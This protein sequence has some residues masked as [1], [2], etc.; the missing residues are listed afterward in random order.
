MEAG[1]GN[2]ASGQSCRTNRPHPPKRVASRKLLPTESCPHLAQRGPRSVNQSATASTRSTVIFEL[3]NWKN[4][5]LRRPRGT[6]RPGKDPDPLPI[7]TM[8]FAEFG[9]KRR[10]RRSDAR[11]ARPL[12]NPRNPFSLVF[13]VSFSRLARERE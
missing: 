1:E 12:R 2:M 5:G 13:S 8:T 3:P 4:P 10:H 9:A 11:V 7:A 6:P